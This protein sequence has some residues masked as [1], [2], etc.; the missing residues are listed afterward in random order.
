MLIRTSIAFTAVLA[1]TACGTAPTTAAKPDKFGLV[2]SG[3]YQPA[4]QPEFM[5][6]IFDGFLGVQ[7][8]AVST[9]VRQVKRADGYRVDVISA[10]FQYVVADIKNDGSYT[11]TRADAAALVDLTAEED[12]SM[13][14]LRKFNATD[15]VKG[16]SATPDEPRGVDDRVQQFRPAPRRQA[17]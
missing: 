17:L 8:M 15:V 13:A 5:D 2:H 6:C 16:R 12:A 9:H 11:L 3:R 4:Q 10:A 14:C 7:N 1:L